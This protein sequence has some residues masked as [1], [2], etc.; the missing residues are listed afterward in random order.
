MAVRQITTEISI[1]NEAEFRKQMKAVNNSLSGM[2]SEMAKVSAEFDGQAN[3]A[4]ALRKKQ[5]ILQ[6]QYDQQKEKVQALAR[7]LANAKSAYDENSDVVLSY[8]RQLN[9]A[10]VE[11]I[12]F[13]RELKNTDKYL[14]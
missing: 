1:K 9:T 13:D 14:D 12:K 6:Q 11:L 10:T 3:S 7:M 4:D 8:Q 5:A 2:K